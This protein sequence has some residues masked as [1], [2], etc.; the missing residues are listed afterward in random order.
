MGKT[1]SKK[2]RPKIRAAFMVV[3]KVL[4]SSPFLEYPIWRTNWNQHIT[5]YE[6]KSRSNLLLSH[7]DKEAQRWIMGNENNYDKVIE[8]LDRYFGDKRKIVRESSTQ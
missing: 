6:E 8:K 7:F 3:D 1:G 2:A 5:D 4:G